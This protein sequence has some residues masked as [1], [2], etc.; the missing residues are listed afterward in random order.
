MTIT[1]NHDSPNIN[2][3]LH[4]HLLALKLPTQSLRLLHL[5]NV[6]IPRP[7]RRRIPRRLHLIHLPEFRH[8]ARPSR[9]RQRA[10]DECRRV[11][12][13]ANYFESV[14]EIC[15]SFY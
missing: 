12:R 14:L 5:G 8:R 6:A 2:P 10:L 9:L 15:F 1:M 13:L 3:L 11:S 7:P 4:R